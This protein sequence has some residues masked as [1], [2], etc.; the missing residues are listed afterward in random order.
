MSK[1]TTILGEVPKIAIPDIRFEQT[2][3][4]ALRREATKNHKLHATQQ[5]SQEKPVVTA[6]IV[7]KVVF[8]DVLLVPFVQGILWTG[9]LIALKPWLRHM[10]FQGRKVGKF[11]YRQ[12]LGT[13][14][15]NK[16]V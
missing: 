3:K 10:V 13:D 12:V 14:L 8:R 4:N 9:F 11:I 6:A 2:F 16:G 7:C 1:P 15:I 5:G